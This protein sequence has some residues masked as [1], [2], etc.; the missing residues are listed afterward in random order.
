MVIKVG[1]CVIPVTLLWLRYQHNLCWGARNIMR[2]PLI[3]CPVA[4]LLLSPLRVT[5]CVALSRFCLQCLAGS[6]KRFNCH[7]CSKFLIYIHHPLMS[8]RLDYASTSNRWLTLSTRNYLNSSF[9]F[10]W[11]IICSYWH[12]NLVLLFVGYVS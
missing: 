12:G 7:C 10:S 8:S 9:P 2:K 3:R 11:H 6:Q 4:I 5:F 1:F